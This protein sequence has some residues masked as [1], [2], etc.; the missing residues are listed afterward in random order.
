ML[1]G[2]GCWKLGEGEGGRVVEVGRGRRGGGGCGRGGR[3]DG[4]GQWMGV[5]T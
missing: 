4:M 5:G 2:G 1:G 3:K